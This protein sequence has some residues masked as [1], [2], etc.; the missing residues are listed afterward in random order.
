MK[1]RVVDDQQKLNTTKAANPSYLVSFMPSLKEEQLLFAARDGDVEK[2]R[3]LSK[4][5]ESSLGAMVGERQCEKQ[6][7]P[8]YG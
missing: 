4:E 5:E 1:E 6:I 8:Y 7:N 2:T 3:Q